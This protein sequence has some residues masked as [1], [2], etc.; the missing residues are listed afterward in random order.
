MAENIF[1]SYNYKKEK[2]L[3]ETEER[4]CKLVE[5][6]PDAIHVKQ[7]GKIV[8]TNDAGAKLLGIENREELM[9]KNDLEFTHPDY[10]T[11]SMER[12]NEM[13]KEN[14]RVAPMEQKCVRA[15]GKI[16]DVEVASTSITF[17]GDHAILS[18]LRDISERKEWEERLQKA[19]EE[20]KNLLKKA[21]ELDKQKTEFFSNISHEFKTPLNVILGT[22]Q[23]IDRFIK[24]NEMP[25]DYIKIYKY[26]GTMKQNCYRLLRLI[27]NLIDINKADSKFIEANFC[28]YDII[29]IIE[30]ITLSVAD[31]G[32]NKGLTLIF[33]TE[34]EE[35]TIACDVDKIE[36]IMLNL[37]S[38]A[39][40][41]TKVGGTI[42]VNI[43]DKE[44]NI[45]INI[46][47][48]G[49]G[50]PNDKL[51]SIFERFEQIDSS[52][53][54]INEGSGIGLSLVKSFVEIHGGKIWVESELGCG[55]Q[56]FIELPSRQ[57]PQRDLN[58][59]YDD[60]ST[61]LVERIS[62]EFSDIYS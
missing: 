12:G 40:K 34:I 32:S 44:E 19:L 42:Y 11:I 4:Y 60:Y 56:F 43:Y 22:I 31:F 21:I 7:N 46:K 52:M 13:R 50:I 58:C 57:I 2:E 62:I 6:L 20:N 29:R 25:N 54:R 45:I 5:L 15:D 35:K 48:T 24:D 53:R 61:N 16:L 49:I 37:L 51:Q 10:H 30:D 18:V 8:F 39:I 36:R 26:I 1:R 33:D 28:N 59:N 17:N 41:Y 23:L 14:N 38:N 55:T 47:D 3:H 9:G 27:N